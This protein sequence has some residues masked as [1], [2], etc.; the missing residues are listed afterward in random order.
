MHAKEKRRFLL[1][2]FS[3]NYYNPSSCKQLDGVKYIKMYFHIGT[4]KI[5]TILK[6]K[7]GSWRGLKNH[8]LD[9]NLYNNSQGR[10]VQV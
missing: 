6:M 4:L 1:I 10:K 2:L 9:Y 7:T 3:F 8:A 5:K